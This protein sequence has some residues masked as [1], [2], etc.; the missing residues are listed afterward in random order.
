MDATRQRLAQRG[1]DARPRRQALSALLLLLIPLSL[2]ACSV[3]AAQ[4][5]PKITASIGA[6]DIVTRYHYDF[7]NYNSGDCDFTID[8]VYSAPAD[9][10]LVGF[11]NFFKPDSGIFA[12][13]TKHDYAYRGAVRFNLAEFRSY[14]GI[15]IEKATLSWTTDHAIVRGVD[16][17]ARGVASGPD[18]TNCV[19]GLMEGLQSP[20]SQGTFLPAVA[21]R[22]GQGDVTGLVQ[23]WVMNGDPNWGFVLVGP[24]ESYNRNNGACLNTLSHFTLTLTYTRA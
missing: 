12:C 24:N 8:H 1:R 23:S 3:P 5:R 2:A 10:L 18:V 21:Y 19:G 20:L 4:L 15:V 6:A 11:D 22:S 17:G 14:A 9:G 7:Y 16:G 13:I